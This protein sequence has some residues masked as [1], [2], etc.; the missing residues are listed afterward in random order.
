MLLFLPSYCHENPLVSLATRCVPHCLCW[1]RPAADGGGAWFG[2]PGDSYV[3]R[4]YGRGLNKGRHLWN[5]C[6]SAYVLFLWQIRPN[7]SKVVSSDVFSLHPPSLQVMSMPY[8]QTDR[9]FKTHSYILRVSQVLARE[10][11]H[12]N[13]KTTSSEQSQK[14][15]EMPSGIFCSFCHDSQWPSVATVFRQRLQHWWV[16]V[17]SWAQNRPSVNLGQFW[18]DFLGAVDPLINLS[19]GAFPQCLTSSMRKMM[20]ECRTLP[21]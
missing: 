10:R 11:N 21:R 14:W 5:G 18:Q 13:L 6:A 19:M 15:F 9:C 7:G 4:R 12:S 8:C 16:R 1:R 2:I 3:D 17:P 20:N